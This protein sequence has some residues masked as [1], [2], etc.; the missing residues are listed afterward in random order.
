MTN[1]NPSITHARMR[2]GMKRMPSG[3]IETTVAL[4][5]RMR[6]APSTPAIAPDAPISGTCPEGSKAMNV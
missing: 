3:K 1:H 4:G 5:Q 2:I 6:Y